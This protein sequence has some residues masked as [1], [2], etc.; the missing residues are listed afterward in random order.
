MKNLRD[1]L[2]AISGKSN[3]VMDEPEEADNPTE[4]AAETKKMTPSEIGRM[5][6]SFR[7]K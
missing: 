4:E 2:K 3:V 7:K 1:R 5:L 6:R